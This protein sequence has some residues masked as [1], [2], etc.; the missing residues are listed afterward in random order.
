MFDIE[1]I[2][3]NAN[4]DLTKFK[5]EDPLLNDFLQR[6][7][8][9]FEHIMHL[10]RTKIVKVN[11]VVVGYFTTEF[12]SIDIPIYGDDNKYPSIVLKCL[13]IDENYENMGIGT[14]ILEYV[15][16]TSKDISEFI[17][18][19]CLFIDARVSK[20]KWYKDRGF[21]FVKAEYNDSSIDKIIIDINDTTVEMFID[22][23]NNSIIE[24]MLD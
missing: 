14:H 23:R 1:L 18:C 17:G 6:N 21:Q 8:A 24:E 12:R 22:F 4:E 16:V 20:L 9:Y 5:C 2:D 15:A 19:R 3:I 7:N 10:S 11:E 13:A